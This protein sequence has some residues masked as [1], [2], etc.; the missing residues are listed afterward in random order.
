MVCD[1]E[2]ARG[3]SLNGD[4]VAKLFHLKDISVYQAVLDKAETGVLME[5][6]EETIERLSVL[7]SIWKSHQLTAPQNRR[8]LALSLFSIVSCIGE[9]QG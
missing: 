4:K 8:H 7:L 3:W 2:R 1:Y 9:L 6:S 5:L